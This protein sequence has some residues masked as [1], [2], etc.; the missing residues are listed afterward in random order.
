MAHNDRQ[1]TCQYRVKKINK[2]RKI[3]NAFI[4]VFMNMNNFEMYLNTNTLDFSQ[5]YSNTN[6]NTFK[7]VFEYL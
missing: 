5:N 4:K 3:L 6:T 1:P 7:N 2:K